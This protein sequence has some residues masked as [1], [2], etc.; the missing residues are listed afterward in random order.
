MHGDAVHR[1]GHAVLTHPVADVMAGKVAGADVRLVL[2]LGVIGRSQV[3]RAADQFG[4]D[5]GQGIEHRTGGL[6]RRDLGVR[7]AEAVAQFGNGSIETG[8]KL[9]ALT[10]EKLR[11][12]FG[13][14]RS[15]PCLPGAARRRATGAGGAPFQLNVLGDHKRWGAPAQPLAGSGDLGRTQWCAVCGGGT[16]LGRR[17]E[18]NRRAAGDQARAVA[19]VGPPDGVRNGLV[20][21]PVDPLGGPAVC[22]EP[23]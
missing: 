7:L 22:G 21:M 1:R 9:R 11:A 3:G 18:S 17:A 14:E 8:G 6:P 12:A 5:L 19:F 15:Q 13:R 10:A 20:I 16:R 4:D 2:G 23:Q